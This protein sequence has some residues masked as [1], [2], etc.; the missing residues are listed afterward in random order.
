[1]PSDLATKLL[2]KP[3]TTVLL[4]NAPIGHSRKLDPLPAGVSVIDRRGKPAGVVIA[5]VR[6]GAELKRLA[7]SF[8]ALEEDSVLWV[9]YPNGGAKAGTDLDRASLHAAMEKH[10]LSEVSAIDF[11]ETWA[12][13]QFS[14]PD[15]I[16]S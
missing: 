11:D 8:A 15:D 7:T 4:L 12:A 6:D 5:F 16:E 13:V 3:D 2:I 9:C 1:M 14:A 10:G